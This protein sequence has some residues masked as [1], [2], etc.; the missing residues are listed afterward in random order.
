MDTRFQPDSGHT[1]TPWIADDHQVFD[2]NGDRIAVCSG[3]V[4]VLDESEFNGWKAN[5]ALIA[6][7]V[8]N[9]ARM[10]TTLEALRD[11]PAVPAWIQTLACGSLL[12]S[13][14]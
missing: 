7:S 1:P 5:A 14:Q 13:Q 2:R 10:V 6:K 3:S 9:H 11:D 8:N 4:S 12:E